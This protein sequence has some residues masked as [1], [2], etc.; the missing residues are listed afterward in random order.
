MKLLVCEMSK[1]PISIIF[2]GIGKSL[3]NP[4]KQFN[5]LNGT[6]KTSDGSM[7]VKRP[8]C[9]FVESEKF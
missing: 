1:Y 7:C 3:W 9:Q 4:F 6:L 2:V 8:M 5:D